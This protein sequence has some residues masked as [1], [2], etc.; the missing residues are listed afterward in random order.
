MTKTVIFGGVL[1]AV[2]VISMVVAVP[3][4]DAAGH[5]FIKKTNVKVKSGILDAKIKSFGFKS[6][7]HPHDDLKTQK[8]LKL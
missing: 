3:L 6:L 4:A 1:A 2:F 8:K 7:Y 5:I